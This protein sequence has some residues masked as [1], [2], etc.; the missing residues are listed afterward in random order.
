MRF[1]ENGVVKYKYLHACTGCG[2]ERWISQRT[3][4]SN[5]CSSC[6]GKQTY[7]PASSSRNDARVKGDGYIT[8]QGYH[9]VFVDGRYVPAHH[10]E[11]PDLLPGQV[12]HHA[13]GNKLH[14]NRPNLHPCTK[15][16]HRD[17]HHQLERLSYFLIQQGLTEFVDGNYAFSPEMVEFLQE[18]GVTPPGPG[19]V[20][21]NGIT[22]PPAITGRVNKGL[23]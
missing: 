18:R 7:V 23:K 12:V 2:V 11:I 10:A 14:N 4:K 3:P 5:R 15:A 20:D 6:A 19:A 8:K 16:E 9:L 21:I 1:V 22:V 13:D 17:V